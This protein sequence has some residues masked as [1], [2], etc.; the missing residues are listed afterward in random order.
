MK[1]TYENTDN[2]LGLL[3]NKIMSVQQVGVVYKL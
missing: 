1:E 2:Y 3:S